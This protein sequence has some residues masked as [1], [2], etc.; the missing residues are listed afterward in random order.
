MARASPE[1][2]TLDPQRLLRPAIDYAENGFPVTYQNS[3]VIAEHAGRLHP[4]PDA[5][6]VFLDRSGRAPTPGTRLRWPQLA[7]SMR[8]IAEQGRGAFYTGELAHR[9]A[10]ASEEMGGILTLEDLAEYEVEWQECL[11]V[12]YRGFK[13]FAPPLPSAGFQSLQ[14][15]KLMECFDPSKLA[16]NSA[17]TVHALVESAKLSITD[18]IACAG[19]PDHVDLPWK[20]CCRRNTPPRR[21]KDST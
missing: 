13:V 10:R 9:I 16:F 2:R 14:H 15:L 6:A 1:T 4:F 12:D 21:G 19:D 11:E 8:E 5:A 20:G 18:R 7:A 3:A 17:D